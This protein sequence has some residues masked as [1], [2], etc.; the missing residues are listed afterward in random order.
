MT[1]VKSRTI[2]FGFCTQQCRTTYRKHSW[3]FTIPQWEL[4][5]AAPHFASETLPATPIFGKWRTYLSKSQPNQFAWSMLRVPDLEKSSPRSLC[6]DTETRREHFSSVPVS[7]IPLLALNC[8]N[9]TWSRAPRD[10]RSEHYAL[11]VIIQINVLQ[12]NAVQYIPTVDYVIQTLA[13]QA[14]I[15]VL[16]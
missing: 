12:I 4:Q 16:A 6:L 10:F 1:F 14:W 9:C 5:M 7:G 15:I 3:L 2:W 13:S 11:A 8:I